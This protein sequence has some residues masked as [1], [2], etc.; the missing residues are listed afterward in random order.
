MV[1]EVV[2]ILVI[3][4]AVAL[5]GTRSAPADDGSAVAD[6][7]PEDVPAPPALDAS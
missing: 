3:V 4:I 6:S 5:A 7:T 1:R 2:A